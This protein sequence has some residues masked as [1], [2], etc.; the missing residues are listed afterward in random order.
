M[1]TKTKNRDILAAALTGFELERKKIDAK[2]K[3]I[4]AFLLAGQ[5]EEITDVRARHAQHSTHA[6][7]QP[8]PK[9]TMSAAAR[10]RISNAQRKRWAE[11]RGIKW[12]AAR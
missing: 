12:K 4:R 7:E 2:I 6:A 11:L 5:E 9:R 8:K 10:K 3:E 1:T